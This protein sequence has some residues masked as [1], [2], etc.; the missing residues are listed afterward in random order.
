MW[1]H[2]SAFHIAEL[3]LLLTTITFPDVELVVVVPF[4]P[5]GDARIFGYKWSRSAKHR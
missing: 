2:M 5:H 4:S 1:F 3:K